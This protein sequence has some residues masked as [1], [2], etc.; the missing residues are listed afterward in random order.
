M[1]GQNPMKLTGSHRGK[2]RLAI[3]HNLPCGGGINVARALIS[4]LQNY[5]IIT[6]H[7]P[8]GSYVPDFPESVLLKEWPF[9]KGRRLSG[10]RKISAPFTL[11]ARLKSFD[12]LCRKMSEE[13]NLNADI[14]LVHN[15]MYIAAPPILNYLKIPSAYFCYEFPRHLYEPELVKRTR[16]ILSGLLLSP[17]RTLERN[18]DKAAILSSDTVITF[19]E[20]M[21][22]R[23]GEIYGLECSIVRPGVDTEFFHPCSDSTLEHSVLSIGALWPFKGHEMAVETLSRMSAGNRPNLVVISDR[24]FRGYGR[25]LEETAAE[26]G[27][28]LTLRRKISKYDLRVLYR[29]SQAVLCCQHNEPY[30]LVPLEAMACGTPVIAVREGGFM[31]NIENGETGILVERDPAEMAGALDKILSDEVLRDRL[32][33]KGREFVCM[34]RSESGAGRRLADILFCTMQ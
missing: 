5:F 4:E 20:W 15:S 30:G 33:R 13:I 21:R 11:P 17:L 23:I 2:P 18:M 29:T 10:M 12:S 16:G 8:E 25:H 31:D 24:E 34:E 22:F 14:A 32:A 27:V 26:K 3:F 6:V 19:S 28:K 7:F 9:K 1:E